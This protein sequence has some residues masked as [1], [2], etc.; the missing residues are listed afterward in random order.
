MSGLTITE[1][2][3]ALRAQLKANLDAETNV[4]P[5]GVGLPYPCIRIVMDGIPTYTTSYGGVAVVPFRLVIEP[6]GTD[7]SAVE[8]LDAYLSAGLGNNSSV[9]DAIYADKTLGGVAR[10]VEIV[11]DEGTYDA[12]NVSASLLIRVSVL[13]VRA[14]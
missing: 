2:R 9:V 8:R 12:E 5:H 14:T 6:A 10:D 1:I 4:D 11:A 3:E 13:K 7:A